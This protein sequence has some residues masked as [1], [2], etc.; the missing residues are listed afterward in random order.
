M[1]IF[2]AGAAGVAFGD[3]DGEAIG[4]FIPGMDMSI[5]SGEA[6]G[7]ADGEDD[8]ICIPGMFI[9]SGDAPGCTFGVCICLPDMP[10]IFMSIFRAGAFPVRDEA[11]RDEEEGMF[12]PF[13]LIPVIPPLFDVCFLLAGV[14]FDLDFGLLLDLLPMFMPGMFCM[15]CPA[16]T[17]A[18]DMTSR[19]AT[20]TAQ[21]FQREII[22]KL[23]MIPSRMI[24]CEQKAGLKRRSLSLLSSKLGL[25]V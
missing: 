18:A 1:S 19:K 22:L 7:W 17:G 2:S 11:R 20:A 15:S 9:C 10:G 5:F 3:G 13:I 8:G 23:F 21:N 25:I 24:S 12:L 4:M 14:D 16:Q 6:E